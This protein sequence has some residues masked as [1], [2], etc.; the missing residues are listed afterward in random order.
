MRPPWTL[1]VPRPAGRAGD[2]V[3][4]KREGGV[5]PLRLLTNVWSTVVV[6]EA[7]IDPHRG[8]DPEQGLSNALDA[9]RWWLLA[10]R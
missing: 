6:D 1:P 10:A 3:A 9:P 2:R 7:L 5:R 8:E 4:E